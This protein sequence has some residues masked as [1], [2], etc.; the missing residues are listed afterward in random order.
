MGLENP[1]TGELYQL[2]RVVEGQL[3]AADTINGA[4]M[5]QHFPNLV[6]LNGM[7]YMPMGKEASSKFMRVMNI[8][9]SGIFPIC[10]SL[11]L[12]VFTYTMVLEKETK[13]LEIMKM[14][15]LQM[16]NYWF[17]N[18]VFNF[19]I[20]SVGAFVFM[21]FGYVV[22]ALEIFTETSFIL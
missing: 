18:F 10:L 5:R 16:K 13:L 12:P 20:Y 21:F 11:F 4:F 15:G 3:M 2:I 1:E 14:N 19:L 6:M 17:M 22:F 7:Q 9:S 8:L